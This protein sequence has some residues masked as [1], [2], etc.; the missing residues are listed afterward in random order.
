ML[1]NL[2]AI[3]LTHIFDGLN[4]AQAATTAP[5]LEPF[6]SFSELDGSYQGDGWIKQNLLTGC[7]KVE[8]EGGQNAMFGFE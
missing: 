6:L 8:G 5:S 7:H 1:S 2:W 3:A 4:I